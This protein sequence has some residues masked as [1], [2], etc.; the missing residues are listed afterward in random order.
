MVKKLLKNPAFVIG[1]MFLFGMFAGSII[2]YAGWGDV[3]PEIEMMKDEEG[4][5]FRG[6]Y[7]PLQFPPLG[8]DNFDRNVLLV[9]L[10][11]AKYTIGAGLIITFFR[12]VPSVAMGLIL[13]FYMKPFKRIIDH[14]VDATNYFPPTLLAF[15]LL[16][17][18][19]LEGPL[20]NPDSYHYVFSDKLL[21]YVIILVLIS[22]PS[23]TLLFS[24]EYYKIMKHEFIDTAKVLGATK[25]HFIWNHI[26][27]FIVPQILLVCIREFM[28]VMLLIAHLGVLN[29]YIGGS[30]LETDVFNNRVFVSLSNEWSGLLG[31][32]WEFLWTTF[33]WISFIPVM[34]FTM[35]IISAKLML[36]GATR[37]L[38]DLEKEAPY[39]VDLEESLYEDKEL[40]EM[41]RK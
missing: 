10:V 5:L 31:G 36:I 6:P 4:K 38:T 32:W 26:R 11:G 34:F 40:F 21:F 9:I 22:I 20:M 41:V 17:W 35:T 19:M 25:R 13:H 33:P 8:T 1:F 30:S 37:V 3:V 18:M 14:I 27:P 23:L 15:L 29:I 12:V 28:I 2:Y 16:N 7:S 39:R 24:H